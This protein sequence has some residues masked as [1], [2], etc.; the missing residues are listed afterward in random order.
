MFP[1]IGREVTD[2]QQS[3]ASLLPLRAGEVQR[4]SRLRTSSVA[5][6]GAMEGEGKQTDG[7]G[8]RLSESLAVCRS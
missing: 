3:S 6:W 4:I 8:V 2:R 7:E 5:A 1:G